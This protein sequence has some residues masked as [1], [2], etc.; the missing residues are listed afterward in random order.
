MGFP[1]KGLYFEDAR[2]RLLR[3]K[4]AVDN[5]NMRDA[6]IDDACIH[7]GEAARKELTEEFI[8]KRHTRDGGV[9]SK[10]RSDLN[11]MHM[12]KGKK[13]SGGTYRYN[14]ETGEMEKVK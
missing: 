10:V 13:G 9:K 1:K 7:E 12:L 5:P 11:R 2:Q 6:L 3:Y 4:S 14:K 8:R